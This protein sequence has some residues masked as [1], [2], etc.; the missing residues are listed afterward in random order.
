MS[1]WSGP[2]FI[3]DDWRTRG[4]HSTVKPAKKSFVMVMFHRSVSNLLSH[5]SSIIYNV[6]LFFPSF[7]KVSVVN[8]VH[9]QRKGSNVQ[10][11]SFGVRTKAQ[12]CWPTFMH[13]FPGPRHSGRP[14]EMLISFPSSPGCEGSREGAY[15]WS[16]WL[17]GSVFSPSILWPVIKG[18]WVGKPS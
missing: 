13:N 9:R 16:H 14:K 5:I 1:H 3:E 2:I 17:T 11:S 7:P 18:G 15:G 4:C 12:V 6:F 10:K 8:M